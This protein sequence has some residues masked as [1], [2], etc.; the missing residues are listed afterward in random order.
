MELIKGQKLKLDSIGLGNS[1][2]L[3]VSHSANQLCDVSVFGLDNNQKLVNDDYMTFYNQ[4]VTPCG[5]VRLENYHDKGATF[6]LNL[7]NLPS[8]VSTL[9]LTVVVDGAGSVKDLTEL[10]ATLSGGSNTLTFRPD[11]LSNEKALM[12]LQ[13]Y[14][15]DGWRV[16][17]VGQGFAGGLARLV[18]HFGASVADDASTP[19]TATPA[20]PVSAPAPA[21]APTASTIELKKRL[22]LEKANQTNNPSIID[23]TKKSLVT[24]EKKN[25]LGVQARVALVLDASGSMDWQYKN[26]DVQKVVN[27][28]M[29]LAISFD[30]DGSFEC[31]AFAQ[32]T[33]QL[34]EV[35]LQNVNDFVN[36]TQGG[37]KKWQVGARYNEE[38]PAI[39]AVINYYQKTRDD[40][41]TYVLFISD[42]GVGSS[43]KMQAILTQASSLP[44]FWQFVGIGGS[45]YGVLEKLDDMQGR[46][47]DNCNFFALDKVDGISDERLYELLLEE[48]PLWLNDI[49]RKNLLSNRTLHQIANQNQNQ[50][51]LLNRL[52]GN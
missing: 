46:V 49:K 40:I 15:K 11:D 7:S 41:P 42:G 45:G 6:L 34:D 3:T 39:E 44:I 51:G 52:F 38:I 17:A 26:G 23:L 33:T 29:P 47:V 20:P 37:Y 48:F 8:T 30:D 9:M 36:T 28:L 4:T 50:G 35:T 18:E 1:L 32:K 5:A 21:P 10:T 22:S 24:L 19:P 2:T 12:V 43:R 13:L 31:W 27:R 16:G 25:L 14:Q